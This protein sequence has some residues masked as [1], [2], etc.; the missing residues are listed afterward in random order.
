MH[1]PSHTQTP[2][3]A[4]RRGL[5]QP[6]AA[7]EALLRDSVRRFSVS[8]SSLSHPPL[9]AWLVALSSFSAWLVADVRYMTDVLGF[10]SA[11]AV[12]SDWRWVRCAR[13]SKLRRLIPALQCTTLPSPPVSTW[14]VAGIYA[15][16]CHRI[17]RGIQP[18]VEYGQRRV[19]VLRRGAVHTRV[20][21]GAQPHRHERR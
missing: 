9:S 13:Q 21:H 1:T 3:H 10:R 8:P 5:T 17:D 2:S 6:Q 19:A 18:H 4:H 16:C 12:V 11:S 7:W 14:C 15:Q 20:P